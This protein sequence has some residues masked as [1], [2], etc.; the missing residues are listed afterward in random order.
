MLLFSPLCMCVGRGWWWGVCITP[1]LTG[2]LSATLSTS[3]AILGKSLIFLN[4]SFLIN[5]NFYF[6]GAMRINTPWMGFPG[7]SDGKASAYN[8]GDPGSIPGLGR[9]PREGNGNPLQYS[10]LENSTDGGAWWATVNGVAKCQIQLSNFTMKIKLDT[11]HIIL[12]M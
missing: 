1:V 11:V 7:G 2:V 12:N 4:F 5:G 8:A 6:T 3:L 9:S 10:C